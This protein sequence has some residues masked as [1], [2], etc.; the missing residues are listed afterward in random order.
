MNKEL[1][2]KGER[3]VGRAKQEV[4]KATGDRRTAW[5]RKE[6]QI[7]GYTPGAGRP[8]LRA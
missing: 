7:A 1:K 4:R 2:T 8:T 3:F 5:S 6:E